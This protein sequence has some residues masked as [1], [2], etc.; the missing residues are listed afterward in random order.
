M[1]PP[2]A[3]AFDLILCRN[4]LIYFDPAL[5]ERIHQQFA[6]ALRPGG[7]LALGRVER[8]VGPARRSF[9]AEHARERIYR[10][11]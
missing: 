5:Q 10:R 7:Y 2:A 11:I 6:R 9:Q 3:G 8:V 1:Q 4:V